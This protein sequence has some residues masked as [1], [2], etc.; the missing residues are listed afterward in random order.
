M[1][2]D[3]PILSP[4]GWEM[5]VD[6]LRV[7]T[8]LPGDDDFA[9]RLQINVV[10]SPHIYVNGRE[11]LPFT[12][13]VLEPPLYSATARVFRKAVMA[14]GA[15]RAA[16]DELAVAAAGLGQTVDEFERLTFGT[17]ESAL[18]ATLARRGFPTA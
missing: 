11:V 16:E 9:E 10:W 7:P 12:L 1:S 13:P 8:W 2:A 14:Q 15:A 5:D 6:G 4:G 3:V 17:L 18:R